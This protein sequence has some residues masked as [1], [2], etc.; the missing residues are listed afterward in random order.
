ADLL[1][2]VGGIGGRVVAAAHA[3]P[4]GEE[5]GEKDHHRGADEHGAEHPR[6]RVGRGGA[7]RIV[8]DSFGR[9]GRVQLGGRCDGA[10]GVVLFAGGV[11]ES[12]AG[13]FERTSGAVVGASVAGPVQRTT[14]AMTAS[15]ASTAITPRMTREMG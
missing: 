2:R 10:E 7:W 5:D 4:D 15:N 12:G 8:G 9:H 11:V 3:E 14:T 1:G 6:G 13:A